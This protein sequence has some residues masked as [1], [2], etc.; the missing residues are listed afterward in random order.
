MNLDYVFV[1]EEFLLIYVI[2]DIHGC[3][4]RYIRMLKKIKFSDDDT[5]YV[6]GDVVDRGE[7]PVKILQDMA[8]RD[9]VIYLKGNHEAMASYVL[10][11]LNEE[12]TED[13]AENQ[14]DDK[15]LQ[16]F[17]TWQYNGCQTTMEQFQMLEKEE[18]ADLLDY[19]A[20][21]QLYA[22]V[23]VG[24]KTFILVHAGLGNFDPSKK[25]KDYSPDEL[26]SQR[27]DFNKKLF[28]DS[29]IYVVCGH[30]PTLAITGKAKIFH[31]QNNILVD[32]GAVFGGKLACLCLDTMQEYY[33]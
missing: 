5:L 6:L 20:D 11:K 16:V 17:L 13:N 26:I 31:S 1:K 12:I 33:V 19:M 28:E 15:F 14:L 21:T 27:P 30:T 23:D 9:N 10:E 7:E 18:R 24:E 8:A 22:S 25:L 4:T 29:S 32:C 2:S 3:Y